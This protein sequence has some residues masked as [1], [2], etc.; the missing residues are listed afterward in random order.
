MVEFPGSGVTGEIA[1]VL[2]G[3]VDR[4]I[5]RLLDLLVLRKRSDGSA[6][7]LR[8]LENDMDAG[9]EVIEPCGE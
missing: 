1:P 4:G 3:L 6:G 5:V 8:A 9:A 2:V 7:S